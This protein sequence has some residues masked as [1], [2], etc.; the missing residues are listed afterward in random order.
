M[1]SSTVTKTPALKQQERETQ[2]M[3]A[4]IRKDKQRKRL[5]EAWTCIAVSVYALVVQ[6]AGCVVSYDTFFFVI[7]FYRPHPF[8]YY[9]RACS[10][11]SRDC[12]MLALFLPFMHSPQTSFI[13]FTFAQLKEQNPYHES[14]QQMT[15]DTDRLNRQTAAFKN[16][17]FCC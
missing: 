14:V 10:C 5:E 12:H 13:L 11:V 1:I 3:L 2:R 4:Q 15:T 6:R 9:T 7:V 16:A 8:V 17:G